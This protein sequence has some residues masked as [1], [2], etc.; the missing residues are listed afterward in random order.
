VGRS[1]NPIEIK[2]RTNKPDK[3]LEDN[4]RIYSGHSLDRMQGRG[5]PPCV[6]EDTIENGQR[7]PGRKPGTTAHYNPDNNVTVITNTKTGKVLT[8]RH[9][10]P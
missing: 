6:V 4:G 9:G 5:I 3:I 2:P 8:V 10:R 1:G 7:H